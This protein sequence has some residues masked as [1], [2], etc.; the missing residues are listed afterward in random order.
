MA[1]KRASRVR[2]QSKDVSKTATRLEMHEKPP[3]VR[4]A[5]GERVGNRHFFERGA[6]KRFGNRCPSGNVRKA[7]SYLLVAANV[8]RQIEHF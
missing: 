6:G 4:G 1:D 3:L 7:A 2:F 8:W 5:V